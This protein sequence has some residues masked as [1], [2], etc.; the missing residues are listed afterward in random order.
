LNSV[1]RCKD[2]SG[3]P[4]ES[5]RRV[6]YAADGPLVVAISRDIRKRLATEQALQEAKSRLQLIIDALPAGIVYTDRDDRYLVAN[7]GFERM[8]GIPVERIIGRSAA[9]VLGPE[10]Y[11]A[12]A[13]H[14]RRAFQG[15]TVRFERRSARGDSG[16]RDE[17]VYCV[18]DRDADG[19][20]RGVFE[21]VT[22]VTELKDAQRALQRSEASL[23][24]RVQERTA[25]LEAALRELEAFSY[26]VSHDLRA[27][28]RAIG[29]FARIVADT[30]GAALSEDGRRRLAVVEKNAVKMG[31]LVDDLLTLSRLSRSSLE[32]VPLDLGAMCRSVLE[33]L[34]PLYPG[35]EVVVGAL[36]PAT[37]DATLV[38]QVL[39]NLLDNALKYSSKAAAPRVEVGWSASERAYFVRDNGI[40]LD[41]AYADKLFRAFERL[42]AEASFPGHGIGL[43]ISKRAVERH[44]GRIWAAGAVRAGAT[45]CFTL[46]EAA[47]APAAPAN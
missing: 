29:G 24:R 42:H 12:S 2:G 27:P 34:R 1:Y 18:P 43:A 6:L 32:P 45:F 10:E 47:A 19:Q 30:E 25:E 46:G 28:L 3:V 36:P 22:D 21:L 4:F 20:V 15:E 13:P 26:S 37:G 9:Q 44:G 11:A 8:R 16:L 38:R 35:A 7:R 39:V 23:E 41:M 33:E 5:T 31:E 40:G 17:V 14:V